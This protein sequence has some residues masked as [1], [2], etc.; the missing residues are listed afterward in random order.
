MNVV[1]LHPEDLLDKEARGELSPGE[2][3][4]LAEHLAACEVCRFERAVRGEFRA[5]FEDIAREKARA[6][7]VESAR[8]PARASSRG[9]LFFLVAAALFIA[10]A[11][12]AEWSGIARRAV[13]LPV[14]AGSSRPTES[15]VASGPRESDLAPRAL[16][17][18][19]LL[20]A[21]PSSATSATTSPRMSRPPSSTTSA[22][23]VPAAPTTRAVPVA[24]SAPAPASAAQSAG[25]ESPP[26]TP[27]DAAAL[28]EQASDARQRAA[29]DDA[30]RL[31]GDLL[32]RFPGSNEALA[33]HAI[34]GRLLLDHGDPSGSLPHFDLYL[35]ARHAPLREEALLGRAVALERL[36]RHDDEGVAWKALLDEFPASIH[37][38]R[39]RA[40]LVAL[41]GR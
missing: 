3:A 17:T 7:R 14:L 38:T 15:P 10:S 11:A 16:V 1:D 40:R 32:Q 5:E 22:A 34:L 19:A 8:P 21:V 20:E 4:R 23:E 30:V 2:D 31:Y 25:P 41:G 13:D 35:A 37:G 26:A 18:A 28:F 33:A 6:P 12:A 9:R 39:A 24:A 29:Y 27:V 36:G